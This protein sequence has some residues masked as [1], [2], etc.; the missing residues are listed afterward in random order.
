MQI[1]KYRDFVAHGKAACGQHFLNLQY[2]E[3]KPLLP[4]HLRTSALLE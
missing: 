1:Q 4:L 2:D 3:L